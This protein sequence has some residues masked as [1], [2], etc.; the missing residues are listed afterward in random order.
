MLP[1]ARCLPRS[2]GGTGIHGERSTVDT[3]GRPARPSGGGSRTR[4]EI[5]VS[6][7]NC[8]EVEF[9]ERCYQDLVDEAERLGIRV[10]Q[11]IERATAAWL[12]EVAGEQ[13]PLAGWRHL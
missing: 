11:V 13:V 1:T 7:A 8:A 2:R 12:T 10:E 6:K 3:P 4:E 5:E 9:D